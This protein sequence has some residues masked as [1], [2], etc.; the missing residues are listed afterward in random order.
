MRLRLV[1]KPLFVL[2]LFSRWLNLPYQNVRPAGIGTNERKVTVF[3]VAAHLLRFRPAHL[4]PHAHFVSRRSRNGWGVNCNFSCP[5]NGERY[6][7]GRDFAKDGWPRGGDPP[8]RYCKATRLLLWWFNCDAAP[9]AP[10]AVARRLACPLF[11]RR[12]YRYALVVFRAVATHSVSAAVDHLARCVGVL[13]GSIG[14]R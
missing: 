9:S 6:N 10:I 13:V 11:A 5:G 2:V 1:I 4:R 8:T 3:A 12:A 14:F 7:P